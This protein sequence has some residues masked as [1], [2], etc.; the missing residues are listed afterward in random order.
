MQDHEL[1]CLCSPLK[2]SRFLLSPLTFLFPL[3]LISESKVSPN[4]GLLVICERY[5]V[6]ACK[7][8]S[9]SRS[10]ASPTQSPISSL[11]D[12]NHHHRGP[13]HHCSLSYVPAAVAFQLEAS[14]QLLP[15]TK[16]QFYFPCS[17][18]VI[19]GFWDSNLGSHA[20]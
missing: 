7:H 6:L 11:P 15:E 9:P 3:V 20:C 8:S 18:V 19:L 4:I 13:S 1:L 14:L 17:T 16:A 5:Q 2:V 10:V 12:L